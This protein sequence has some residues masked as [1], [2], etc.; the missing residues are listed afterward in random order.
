MRLVG[1][2]P[3]TSQHLLRATRIGVGLIR[4]ADIDVIGP[5]NELHHPI[6]PAQKDWAIKIMNM[7][8]RSQFLT[9]HFLIND[10][11]FYPLRKVVNALRSAAK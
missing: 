1:L 8:S 6:E 3:L 9:D 7:V 2:D 5:F 10:T 4:K 11:V